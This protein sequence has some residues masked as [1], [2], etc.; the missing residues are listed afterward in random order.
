MSKELDESKTEPEMFFELVQM[1]MDLQ[2][3]KAPIEKNGGWFL[4]N[5]SGEALFRLMEAVEQYCAKVCV[6]LSA[7]HG[8]RLRDQLKKQGA[9]VESS[10]VITRERDRNRIEKLAEALG[11]DASKLDYESVESAS[12]LASMTLNLMRTLAHDKMTCAPGDPCLSHGC[13]AECFCPGGRKG[14]QAT[15]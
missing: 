7:E 11:I 15:A 8:S 6:G 4:T 14:Q 3:A 10:T 1:L 13:G 9:D 12:K 5:E 2:R